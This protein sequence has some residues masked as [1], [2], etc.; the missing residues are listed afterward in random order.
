MSLEIQ[1]QDAALARLARR[2]AE[3]LGGCLW[4][5]SDGLGR[6]STFILILPASRPQLLVVNEDAMT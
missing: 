5:E 3:A 6:G 2:Q 4:A 1:G